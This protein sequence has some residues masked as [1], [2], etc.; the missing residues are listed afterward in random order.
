MTGGLRRSVILLPPSAANW[1]EAR[2]RVVLA[3]ELVHVRR[4]DALRQ[5]AGRAVLSFYWFHPLSWVALHFAAVRREEACDEEVLAAGARPSE[6]AGHLLSLA[7]STVSARP[8]LS[9]PMARRSQL[10]RRVRAILNPGQA[11]PRALVAGA[12]FIAVA[13][14][15]I[16][17]A[18]ANPIR[19]RSA[20][21][22]LSDV[23]AVMSVLVECATAAD[24]DRL[25]GRAFAQADG[26]FMCTIEEDAVAN[27]SGGVR[28]IGPREWAVLESEIRRK[29]EELGAEGTARDRKAEL[30]QP[31]REGWAGATWH[32]VEAEVDSG[33]GLSPR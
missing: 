3:H 27:A 9:L 20:P 10:E 14:A 33:H 13:A 12:T 11:R 2:R 19:P 28:A 29:I 21:D 26:L 18:V 6:Y 22:T 30:A 7:E 16:S 32:T 1:S 23:A 4:R 17:A 5:L 8:V 31:P 15:G 24:A 25:S